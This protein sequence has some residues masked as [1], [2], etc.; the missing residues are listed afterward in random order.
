MDTQA[1]DRLANGCPSRHKSHK[2]RRPHRSL[3]SCACNHFIYTLSL[4]QRLKPRLIRFDPC[5]GDRRE[6]RRAATCQQ[7]G[8][9]DA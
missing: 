9:D 4:A 5:L 1:L 2:T 8:R 3:I 7:L 6:L